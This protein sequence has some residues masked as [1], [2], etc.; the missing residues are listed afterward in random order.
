V[1][2]SGGNR[3]FS[4]RDYLSDY[5]RSRY[6]F[7]RNALI[8]R[9]FTRVAFRISRLSRVHSPCLKLP[10][11][12][13]RGPPEPFVPR[14]R[15]LFNGLIDS[16]LYYSGRVDT[17]LPFDELRRRSLINEEAKAAAGAPEPEFSRHIRASLP[18]IA[19]ETQAVKE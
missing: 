1:K 19:R 6:S 11:R 13:P 16:Y 14:L 18:T 4:A 12:S 17:T 7:A 2:S 3:A 15:H 10:L 8:S 9:A 5:P